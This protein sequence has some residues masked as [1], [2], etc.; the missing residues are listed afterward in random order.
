MK[1]KDAKR[2]QLSGILCLTKCE[3]NSIYSLY[4]CCALKDKEKGCKITGCIRVYR[5]LRFNKAYKIRI[6]VTAHSY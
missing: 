4:H 1:E 3:D 6:L 5:G 2:I